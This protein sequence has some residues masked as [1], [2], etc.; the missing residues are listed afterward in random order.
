MAYTQKHKYGFRDSLQKGDPEKVIYGVYFDD[1]FESLESE[2]EKVFDALDPDGD[3][4]LLHEA[5]KGADQPYARD[6]EAQTWVQTV[7][8]SQYT[9]DLTNIE[10][11]ITEI[12]GDITDIQ[13]DITNI[14]GDITDIKGDITNIEGD[15]NDIKG[16]IT[17]IEGDITTIEG[18]V[19]NIIDGSLPISET[20]PTVPAHVKAIT[21]TQITNWDASF[22]WGNHSTQG[23]LKSFTETDPTVPAHVKGITQTDISNW[24]AA[25]GGTAPDMNLYYTKTESDNKFQPKGSYAAASH[26]HGWGEITG[27]PSTYPPASHNHTWG[28]ITGTPSTYPPASHGHAWGDITGKPSFYDGSDAVKL[29]GNQ[30]IGGAKTF[31]SNVTAPDFVATS[32]IAM[33]MNV[34]TAPVG[35][36]D[37]IRGVEFDWRNSGNAASGVIANEIEKVLPHLVQEHQGVKHVSY[38][39]LIAYLI[40]EIKAL[41][42]DR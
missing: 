12:K 27:K 15:I 5:P 20:D 16:D 21:S 38:M 1:E 10:G 36:I 11:D 31:S 18:N 7:T 32:D 33:K 23:Y 39:G 24:N 30:T 28:E 34:Q 42:N 29:T 19:N 37:Q 25:A 6:G 41:K 8:L 40:E 14:S 9:N 17:N 22:G 35:L 2:L 26:G 3:N 13:G 4:A